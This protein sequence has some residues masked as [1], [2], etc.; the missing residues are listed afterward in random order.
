MLRKNVLT[1]VWIVQLKTDGG[2]V[3]RA[4]RAECRQAA[5]NLL[6]DWIEENDAEILAVWEAG[7]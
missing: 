5:V 4:V 2:V 3:N 6:S 7:R 1:R